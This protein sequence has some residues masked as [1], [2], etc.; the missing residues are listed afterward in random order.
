MKLNKA[1]DYTLLVDRLRAKGI[2]FYAG[3]SE[4]EIT[5]IEQTFNFCFPLD[6]KAFLHTALPA[7]E[8][9]IHWRQALY[10]G[11]IEREVKQR[12]NTP[13]EGVL[14]DVMKNDF[15]LD[16]WGEKNLNLD[17]RKDH[18]DKISNQCPVL[19]PLYRN[20]YMATS[21][22]TG[23]NPVYSVYNSDIICTGNDLACW[24]KTEFNLALPGNYQAD[25][26]P[27]QFWDDFL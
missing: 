20:R 1:L 12:F 2:I 24:M 11:K 7:S 3:L 15:W 21:L 10:S 17:S 18:F 5:T 4:A 6:F 16:V 26:N 25:K 14:Y 27:V 9:F 8:G 19:I 23:G 13:I 22:H